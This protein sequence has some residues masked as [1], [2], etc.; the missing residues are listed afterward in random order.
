MFGLFVAYIV[1]IDI[2]GS[3]ALDSVPIFPVP[4]RLLPASCVRSSSTVLTP[5]A[6]YFTTIWRSR[7]LDQVKLIDIISDICIENHNLRGEISRT[8]GKLW[9][10]TM[11]ICHYVNPL[12]HR[13]LC[14][15]ETCKMHGT[16]SWPFERFKNSYCLF[17]QFLFQ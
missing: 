12:L 16:F 15:P 17:M 6:K 11:Y 5:F 7:L 2:S 14:L 4:A 3:F 1:S 9:T 13:L 10:E 8:K